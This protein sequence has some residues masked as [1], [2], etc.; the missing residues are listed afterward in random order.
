MGKMLKEIIIVVVAGTCLIV[1]GAV[2]FNQ[3]NPL[4]DCQQPMPVESGQVV[5][6]PSR[7]NLP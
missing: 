5:P 2:A 7:L 4:E 6:R 3:L 1:I